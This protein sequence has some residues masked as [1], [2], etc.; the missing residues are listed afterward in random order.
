MDIRVTVNNKA[1]VVPS[2]TT[3]NSLLE[4][5]GYSSRVAIWINGTQLLGSEY[6]TCIPEDGDV[7]KILRLAAG[8]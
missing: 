1:T 8:G 6:A 5:A 2:G 4:T 3:V 7:I